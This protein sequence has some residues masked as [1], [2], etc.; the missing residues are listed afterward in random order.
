M[1]EIIDQKINYK[2]VKTL[3]KT[4]ILKKKVFLPFGKVKLIERLRVSFFLDPLQMK[5]NSLVKKE[6]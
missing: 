6:N 2:Q 4:L 5:I 1:N 3:I